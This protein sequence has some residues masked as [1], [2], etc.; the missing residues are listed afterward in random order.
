MLIKFQ[1]PQ[2]ASIRTLLRGKYASAK[3]YQANQL[4]IPTDLLDLGISAGDLVRCQTL[5]LDRSLGDPGL[6]ASGA[7][8]ST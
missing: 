4:Y 1:V 8:N 2:T 5:K 6:L 3:L 7:V